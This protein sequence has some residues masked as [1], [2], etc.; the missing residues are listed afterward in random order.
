MPLEI[1]PVLRFESR[2]V[3]GRRGSYALRVAT[4]LALLVLLG[5]YQ[6]AFGANVEQGESPTRAKAFLADTVALGLAWIHLVVALL[7]APAGAASAL[8]RDRLGGMLGTLLTT[9]LGS[10]RIVLE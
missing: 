5:L 7:V 3:A 8:S 10:W 4:G 2:L 1:G 6:W 9:P